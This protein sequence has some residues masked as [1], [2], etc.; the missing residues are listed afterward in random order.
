MIPF[1]DRIAALVQE[2]QLSYANTTIIVPSDRMIT[3]L[4]QAF[5]KCHNDV[6]LLP[7]MQTIDHW[8]QKLTPN[9]II[10]KS[11]ALFELYRIFEADPIEHEIKTFDAFLNWGQLLLS[12]FDE[13]DR[14]LVDPNQLFKNLRDVREIENWSFNHEQLSPGQLKFMAF[15]DKLGPYY[16]AFEKRLEALQ[17]T[18]KGKAYRSLANSLDRVFEKNK[19]SQFVFAGFNA[20]S[21]AE[22]SIMKQL[23]KMGR[24]LIFMDS[25]HYYFDDGFHEAGTFQRILVEQLGLK[26]LPFIESNLATKAL[27]VE[28]IECPQQTGQAN[29][30]GSLLADLDENQLN[31]T[32]V[33]L[34]DEQLLGTLLQHLPKS[35]GKANI[36]LGL[37]LRQ[38]SLRLWVDLIFR[39]QEAFQRRGNASIYHKDF[40]Q[41]VHHP[42]ILAIA[43]EQALRKIREIETKIVRQN[44][45]FIDRKE[46]HL[47]DRLEQLNSLLFESWKG[48]WKTAMAKI[49][50]MNRLLDDWLG[51]EQTLEKAAIRTFSQALVGLENLLHEDHP[52]MNLS[53]F[54]IFFQQHWSTQN[55]AYFGNPLDG[56]QIMGLLETRGLDFKRIFVLGLN[57]GT[58]PPTNPIQTLIPMDLRRFFHLPTPREKQGLFAHHFY[59][60]LHSAEEMYITYSAANERIGSNEPSRFIQQI[61]LELAVVN[62]AVEITK[63]FYTLGNEEKIGTHK[64]VKTP[65]LIARID[66]LMKEGLTYSKIAAFLECPLNFYYRYILRIGEENKVE[67]E[68]ESSTLG[69]ILHQVLELLY[70]P[71]TEKIVEN[72]LQRRA[73]QITV[74]VVDDL[75]KRAP[76]LIDEAFYEHFSKDK[77]LWQTGTNH[78]T[79]VMAKEI[80][81]KVLLKEKQTLKDNPQSSLFIQ[82]LEKDIEHITTFSIDGKEKTVRFH[83]I[84]DRIDQ[85]D[86]KSRVIDYKSGALDLEKVTVKGSTLSDVAEIILKNKKE[87]KP[88]SKYALQLMLYCYLYKQVMKKDL[89][90]VGIFSF[91]SIMDSPFYLQLPEDTAIP[92]VELVEEIIKEILLEIYDTE[93]EFEHNPEA[94]YCDYCN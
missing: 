92:S 84:I 93:Q 20:L 58:M 85:I 30:I 76:L 10:E 86:G 16:F 71:Y 26:S 32:L 33:L 8:V 21:E 82:S 87:H 42:F 81:Q 34:A 78:I 80:I 12:D 57:E 45:H 56:L 49:Q 15:W 23:S 83:G 1:V 68:I 70:E 72:E 52:V 19:A 5:Y 38:T 66:E 69:S 9:P 41:Y 54:K 62:P 28:V 25:D 55:L 77:S 18:T 89:D 40:I 17:L 31:E 67:E 61:E 13:I 4:Q 79:Y 37:P 3:Y 53:T 44:W 43:D 14:Y 29:V 60:L 2:H 75:L 51:V 88:N 64:V 46:M 6:V 65:E 59:R 50:Q 90:E 39:L 24:G 47:G 63:R 7:K 27:K 48:N 94:K 91:I 36:T 22:L 74:D 11:A 35:I 73:R